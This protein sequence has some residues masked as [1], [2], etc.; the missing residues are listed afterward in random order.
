M[1]HCPKCGRSYA[2]DVLTCLEDNTPL[3]ADSTIVSNMPAD[4]LIGRAFDDKYRLDERI[5]EGGMGTVYRATHLLIDR[6]VAIKVLNPRLVTDEAARE[7][8][9]REARAAGR[10][11]HTNAVAVTDFG[12]TPDGYVYIVMELLEGHSLRDVLV[13]S[14]PL[15]PARAVSIML[16]ISAAVAAAHEAGIIHRDLKPGNIFI[17]ERQ[18]APAIVKVL[19]FGIAKVALEQADGSSSMTLTEA[20]VMIGTPRYMSPEQCDGAALTPA[21]DVYSL[22]TLLYEMLAGTTPFTGSTPLAVA[23]KQSSEMPRPPREIVAA[24]PP[25][26]EQVV[27]HALEKNPAQR[28]RDAREFRRELYNVAEQL[29]L[30]HAAGFS[31][32]T[33]ETLRGAGTETPSGRLI[34][35]IE[36]LRENRAA[37][38]TEVMPGADTAQDK[39]LQTGGSPGAKAVDKFSASSSS[40]ASTAGNSASRV[41]VPLKQDGASLAWFK[42]PLALLAAGLIGLVLIVGL[43]AYVAGKRSPTSSQTSA[44][45]NDGEALGR[46]LSP[47]VNVPQQGASTSPP[48]G[49][50]TTAAEFYERGAYYF[51]I[52][53][54]DAAANDFRQAIELQKDFPSA[55]NRLGQTLMLK[56]QF[57]AAASE[58]RAAIEQK[59]GNYPAAQYNL[60]FALQQQNDARNALEAYRAAIDARGGAYSDAYYQTGIILL[61]QKHYAEA[62]DALRKAIEQNDEPDADAQYALGTALAV[63]Q[64]Y[65]NAESALRAAIDARNGDFPEAH[66]N[67]G[68]LYDKASRPADA[69]KEYERYLQQRPDASNRR[70]V[71]NSLK[72]LRRRAAK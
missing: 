22:G 58:F 23:L 60:G 41:R 18:H 35:D 2:D 10:L 71:E 11:Q 63:Q 15:D 24:I 26:L 62:A 7:R 34:I 50:P 21:S 37:A 67:L 25:A 38:T 12:E 3:K 1:L 16:Q 68:L 65:T 70:L 43:V 33:I 40:A 57:A 64:D 42:Q 31:A 55:H 27:L 46:T 47:V 51:S 6:P 17:V 4:A 66:Y 29:G 53:N 30:E 44:N 72:D 52:R 8:F 56:G 54:Q 49:E 20:G 19:D 45:D 48:T 32:P 5:G 9:R 69:I 36:R 28:P 39:A 13:T 59:G 61:K 14:A